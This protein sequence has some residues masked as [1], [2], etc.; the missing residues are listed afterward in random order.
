MPKKDNNKANNYFRSFLGKKI[1]CKFKEIVPSCFPVIPPPLPLFPL[2]LPPQNTSKC[3]MT[4]KLL[5]KGSGQA[6]AKLWLLCLVCFDS[7]TTDLAFKAFLRREDLTIQ[8]LNYRQTC[9]I[10]HLVKS[11]GG[12]VEEILYLLTIFLLQLKYVFII[13]LTII[14]I[15]YLSQGQ[16]K[17]EI[18]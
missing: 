2:S 3:G 6:L 11:L 13:K 10:M 9:Y 14:P 5:T 4:S 1:I 17:L 18:F 8:W 15:C 12:G 7:H 16:G